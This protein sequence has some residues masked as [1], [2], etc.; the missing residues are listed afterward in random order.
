MDVQCFHAHGKGTDD[1]HLLDQADMLKAV[2]NVLQFRDVS[3][4]LENLTVTFVITLR[5]SRISYLSIDLKRLSCCSVQQ[6]E[7]ESA[8]ELLW[9][10]SCDRQNASFLV[11]NHILTLLEGLIPNLVEHAVHARCL[12]L[13]LGLAANVMGSATNHND[14]LSSIEETQLVC[15]CRDVLGRLSDS[16]CLVQLLR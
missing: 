3:R 1:E 12:E 11:E 5:V 10:Y 6:K 15:R 7:V 14:L 9:D 8:L 2:R 13:S 4:S 16:R